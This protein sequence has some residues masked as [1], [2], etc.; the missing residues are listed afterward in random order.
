VPWEF[1]Y[2]EDLLKPENS[3]H[4]ME[5]EPNFFDDVASGNLADFIWL[6]PRMGSYE[7]KLPTW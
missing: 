2:F 4:I 5:L 7:D 6:Q 1:G 3:A